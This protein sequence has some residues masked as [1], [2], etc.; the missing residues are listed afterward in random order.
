MIEHLKQRETF[1]LTFLS[2]LTRLLPPGT[3]VLKGGVNLRFFFM[4]PRYSEDMDLDVTDVPMFKL[5]DHV[6]NILSHREFAATL[7]RS[8]I[9]E[10]VPP[11]L[12][13][14]KQTETV[15]RFKVHLLTAQGLDLFTKIEF[16]RRGIKDTFAVEAISSDLARA[17]HIIPFII[18]HYDVIAAALQ[19]VHALIGRT[20]PQARDVFDL[21]VLSSQLPADFFSQIP[22][23]RRKSA[24]NRT[25]TFD[26]DTYNGS[27]VE[28]L[29]DEDRIVYGTKDMWETIQLRIIEVLEGNHG[30]H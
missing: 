19:K 20:K 6:M 13:V 14:A 1:H 2:W 12:S 29:G 8:G 21:F 25:L 22:K 28:F 30:T 26:F 18:P 11:D 15:Q 24:V 23:A 9:E 3:F 4:N 27:V 16:S 17:H 10:I 7:K 5:R